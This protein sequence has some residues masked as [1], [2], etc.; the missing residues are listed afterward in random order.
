MLVSLHNLTIRFQEEME[1]MSYRDTQT[2]LQ[3]LSYR[4]DLLLTS[5]V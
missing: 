3:F 5:Q 1:L 4:G 2:T